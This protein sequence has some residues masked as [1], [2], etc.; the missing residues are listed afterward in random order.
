MS[1]FWF[2]TV[3]WTKQATIIISYSP[4][5]HTHLEILFG[6]QP[7]RSHSS[8]WGCCYFFWLQPF[9]QTQLHFP[10]HNSN[11]TSTVRG[12]KICH[13]E[14]E[15]EYWLWSTH[16]MPLFMSYPPPQPPTPTSFHLLSLSTSPDISTII[17]LVYP[18]QLC[19]GQMFVRAP[20]FSAFTLL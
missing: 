2:L 20:Y 17:T 9:H 10:L 8:I 5:V 6:Y 16:V 13:W 15:R 18:T 4:I 12:G 19:G 1:I 7:H 3:D 14:W 11:L